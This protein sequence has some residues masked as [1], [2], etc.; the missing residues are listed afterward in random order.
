VEKKRQAGVVC[1]PGSSE[2]IWPD[3]ATNLADAQL[4]KNGTGVSA[5]ANKSKDNGTEN[6]RMVEDERKPVS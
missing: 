4:T 5:P 3:P 6:I 2:R 1:L